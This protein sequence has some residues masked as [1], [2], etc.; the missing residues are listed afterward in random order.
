MKRS[1]KNP[2]EYPNRQQVDLT[3]AQ[4][5]QATKKHV[6]KETIKFLSSLDLSEQEHEKLYW[7]IVGK[8]ISKLYHEVGK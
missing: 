8:V 4:I 2:D 1:R 6:G 5:I 3:I 7:E